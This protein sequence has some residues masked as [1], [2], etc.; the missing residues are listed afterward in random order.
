[1]GLED[2]LGADFELVEGGDPDELSG[3]DILGALARKSPAALRTALAR[4]GVTAVRK[5]PGLPVPASAAGGAAVQQ[6]PLGLGAPFNFGAAL[7]AGILGPGLAQKAGRPRRLVLE[8][9]N[10]T[11]VAAVAGLTTVTLIQIGLDNIQIGAGGMPITMFAALA[12]GVPLECN[13]IF[14]GQAANVTLARTT[15]GGAGAG[16]SVSGAFLCDVIQ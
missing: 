11:A 4:R 15:A 16:W 9:G 10:T 12:N 8:E 2:I 6:F 3:E 1:M 13:P 5:R 14:I 7:L